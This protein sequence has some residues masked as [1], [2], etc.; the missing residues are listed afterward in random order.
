VDLTLTTAYAVIEGLQS[1]NTTD[2][3][4]FPVHVEEDQ[5]SL[6][7]N[8]D[9]PFAD[10]TAKKQTLAS[11]WFQSKRNLVPSV[12]HQS[13]YLPSISSIFRTLFVK[14]LQTP[15]SASSVALISCT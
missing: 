3:R 8:A 10:N 4:P 13:H 7:W 11:P 1:T 9:C 6:V 15:A 14:L 5:A 2:W 12:T